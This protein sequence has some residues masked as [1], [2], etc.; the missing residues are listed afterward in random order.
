MSGFEGQP[1]WFLDSR[2]CY[3]D[4]I[5]RV[6]PVSTSCNEGFCDAIEQYFSMK[7]KR[8]KK[9]NR[10]IWLWRLRNAAAAAMILVPIAL[11]LLWLVWPD[12]VVRTTAAEGVVT[13]WTRQQSSGGAG[14][15]VTWVTLADGREV[16]VVS[17]GN[18]QVRVGE[19]VKLERVEKESGASYYRYAR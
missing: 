19:A 6:V 3:P 12:P 17:G 11:L 5:F 18:R 1:A 16:Q 14:N 13:R 15:L 4:P 9:L 2:Y 7:S 8:V 10:L